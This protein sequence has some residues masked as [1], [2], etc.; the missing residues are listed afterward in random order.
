LSQHP[1][2]IELK[3]LEVEILIFENKL[4]RADEILNELHELAF[5]NPDIC[6]YKANI[7]SKQDAHEEAIFYLKK[8]EKLLEDDDDEVPSLIAMEYMFLED[9]EQAKKYFALCLK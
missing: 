1:H 7:L 3:L 8:A 6:I 4:E 9:Y 2:A 5:T